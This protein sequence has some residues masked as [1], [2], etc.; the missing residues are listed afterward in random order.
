[1]VRLRDSFG[2]KGLCPK[3]YMLLSSCVFISFSGE[4]GVL[5]GFCI[6]SQGLE[7]VAE[8]D[9]RMFLVVAATSTYPGSLCGFAGSFMLVVQMIL[10]YFF[11]FPF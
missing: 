10:M 5:E 8:K 1:M 6:P 2:G 9:Y 3:E 4:A 11:P 7:R